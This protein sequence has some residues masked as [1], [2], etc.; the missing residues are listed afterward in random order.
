MRMIIQWIATEKQ[1]KSVVPNVFWYLSCMAALL[2]TAAFV[3]RA[4]WIFAVGSGLTILI[5]SRNIWFI[6]QGKQ[7]ELQE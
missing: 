2:S 4:E 5:Y 1:K 3:H 6:L 7:E